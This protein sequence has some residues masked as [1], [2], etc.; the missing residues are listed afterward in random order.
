MAAYDQI[1]RQAGA[2]GDKGRVE[3]FFKAMPHPDQL[4]LLTDTSRLIT[5]QQR[6]GGLEAGG[7]QMSGEA[8]WWPPG[9]Q[10]GWPPGTQ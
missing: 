2:K 10:V 9:G 5:C 7:P 4:T 1:F 3:K 6:G 8:G